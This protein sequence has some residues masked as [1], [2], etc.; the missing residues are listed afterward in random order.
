[1]T[2]G[3]TTSLSKCASTIK[4][5]ESVVRVVD[6]DAPLRRCMYA[7]YATHYEASEPVRFDA[8]LAAKQW[9]I[10]LRR[11]N[12]AL[13]GFSTV[14]YARYATPFGTVRAV[15]SGDTVIER[16]AWGD[17]ALSRAFA[18]LCGALWVQDAATPLY[19]LLISKGH[20]TYRYLGLFA[21]RYVPHPKGDEAEL[22]A[23]ADHL[24][25]ARFGSH[26]VAARGV[27]SFPQSL[28]HLRETVA[29]VA[30]H[31]AQRPDVTLFLERNPGWSRGEE[32]VCL[33]PLYPDNLRS[34]VRSAFV[35]GSRTGLPG[36]ALPAPTETHTS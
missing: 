20:R 23:L 13:A 25:A 12:G 10:L 1:M 32:L 24:A 5:Y 15:F 28:G 33:A 29:D 16:N 9:V 26:Y 35:Q 17:Q 30:P 2:S 27:V 22:R 21:H 6:L 31:L 18:T 7:L 36:L 3:T 34:L 11:E 8:D 4:L 19:W 14:A